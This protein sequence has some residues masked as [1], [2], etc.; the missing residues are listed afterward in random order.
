MKCAL[1]SCTQTFEMV[2]PVSHKKYCS[3]Y[4]QQKAWRLSHKTRIAKQDRQRRLDHYEAMRAREKNSRAKHIEEH[5]AAGRNYWRRKQGLTS[6]ETKSGFC[7]IC[8]RFFARLQYDHSHET[9]EHRGWLCGGCNMKLEWYEKYHEQARV[10]LEKA[11][12]RP[13]LGED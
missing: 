12:R 9:G 10:Y 3:D 5:R 7:E 4:C 2:W 13:L 8:D 6:T 1:L 11:S